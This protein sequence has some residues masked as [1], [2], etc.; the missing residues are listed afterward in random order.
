MYYININVAV[1]Q[2][3][4]IFAKAKGTKYNASIPFIF[5]FFSHRQ[6]EALGN[7]CGTVASIH[8]VMNSGTYID[9]YTHTYILTYMHTYIRKHTRIY[10][11]TLT[12]I[13]MTIYVFTLTYI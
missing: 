7:A 4:K 2:H 10:V 13:R 5:Y 3:V 12:Y 8:S 9:T 6:Q 1:L 11:N